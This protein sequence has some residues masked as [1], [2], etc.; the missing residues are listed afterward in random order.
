MPFPYTFPFNLA[1]RPKT[2]TLV[3]QFNFDDT[4]KWTKVGG[5]AVVSGQASIPSR[6]IGSFFLN[7]LDYFESVETFDFTNSYVYGR[8]PSV[9]ATA[10][11]NTYACLRV[12]SVKNPDQMMD[13]M[14]FSAGP[15]LYGN[16]W[17]PAQWASN[18]AYNATSQAW[19]RISNSGSTMNFDAAPD[20]AG[21]PGTWTSVRS[22]ARS[23][24]WDMTQVKVQIQAGYQTGPDSGQNGT[25][26]VDNINMSGVAVTSLSPPVRRPNYG[27]LIQF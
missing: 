19:W 8:V 3:D 12:R 22:V 5:A 9:P 15:V 2:E 16:E 14:W 24:I 11:N 17:F 21:A 10:A 18:V 1:A 23:T 20:S 27:S 13:I 25:F 7:T 26:L 6:F 4:S